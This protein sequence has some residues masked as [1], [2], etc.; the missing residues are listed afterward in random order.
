MES[1]IN[2]RNDFSTSMCTCPDQARLG[3]MQ[4]HTAR[5]LWALPAIDPQ[6]TSGPCAPQT[7]ALELIVGANRG[8]GLE[9]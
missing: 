6:R 8:L 5:F 3:Q 9:G 2:K 4:L 7:R 1:S